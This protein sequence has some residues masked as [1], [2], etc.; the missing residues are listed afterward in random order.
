MSE[1]PAPLPY[2]YTTPSPKG[3]KACCESHV[4]AESPNDT[5]DYPSLMDIT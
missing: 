5:V 2:S 4:P 1:F 3:W